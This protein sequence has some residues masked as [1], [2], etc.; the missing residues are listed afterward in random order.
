MLWRRAQCAY[1]TVLHEIAQPLLN[2]KL[3]LAKLETLGLS[4]AMPLQNLQH[5]HIHP[6]VFD[7]KNKEKTQGL[8]GFFKGVRRISFQ[9]G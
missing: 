8:N 5:A 7:G 9:G 4:I 6:I 3:Q 1:N 2:V